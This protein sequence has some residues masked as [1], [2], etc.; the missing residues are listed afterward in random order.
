MKFSEVLKNSNSLLAKHLTKE[1]FEQLKDKK[2]KSGVTLNDIIKSGVK[3]LDS[4]IGAYA[5]DEESYKIFA[6][7]FDEIIADYHGYSKTGM[8]KSNLN[9]NDLKVKNIDPDDKYIISTRI[10]VGRNVKNYPLGSTITN[11]QRNAIEKQVS[12]LLQSLQGELAGNYYP[13]NNLTPKTRENLISNHFLFKADDRF[14]EAAGLTRDWPNGRGIYHNTNKTFL[15]W[16]NEED[17]LRIISMQKGGDINAVFKRLVS[18]LEIM[19]QKIDF[20]YDKHLGYMASC[21][22][23]LGTSLRASVHIKLPNLSKNNT[24]FKA[25]ADEFNVQIRGVDGEHSTNKSHIYDISNKRRLGITEVQC[26]QDM[27]NG[28]VALIKRE[29]E[30]A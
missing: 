22:T 14:L 16:I 21:P 18:A 1:I 6:P 17:Q 2:T 4:G 12:K 23:N 10:R 29:Q 7:L 25:I 15:V 3:N 8:H 11:Q 26:V 5:G 27:Y 13:L 19:Q 28:V 30:L 20:S 9:S 24:E